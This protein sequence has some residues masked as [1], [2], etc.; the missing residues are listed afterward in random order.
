MQGVFVE[1]GYYY[2]NVQE[3]RKYVSAN[4]HYDVG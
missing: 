1:Q 2:G 3:R 4:E